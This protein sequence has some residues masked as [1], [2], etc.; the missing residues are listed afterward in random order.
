M[1]LLLSVGAFAELAYN[2]I[3]TQNDFNNNKTV[4]SKII[5][6]GSEVVWDNG[7]IRCGG[8]SS[9]ITEAP[10]WN[11]DDKG[12]V[13][14]LAAGVPNQLSFQYATN[15]VTSTKG[16]TDWSAPDWY[17][18]ESADGSKWTNAWT[19][20]S[21]STTFSSKTVNLSATTRFIR[22]YFS[23]NFAGYFKDIKVTEQVLM[24][25][26]SPAE[27]DFGTV[28]VDDVATREFTIN[29][30]GM[31]PT[32][33]S[34]NTH[35]TVTPESF[36]SLY[37]Y[38]KNQTIT[39]GL[40][41]TEAGEYNGT[42]TVAGRGKSA[43]VAVTAKVEKYDQ[44]INWDAVEAYN[45]G[46]AIPVATATSG[47]DVTYE[48][49]NPS[50]LKFENGAF[51]ILHSGEATVTAKQAGNYKYNAAEDVVKTITVTAPATY[52][53][54]EQT[55][56][57][58]SVTFFGKEYTESA[59]EDVKVG[60]NWMG[61]DSIVR[62]AI[63][64]NHA[65]FSEESLTITY[66]DRASWNGAALSDS[67][68]GVHT[69]VYV[70]TNA[71]GCDST[72][73]LTL[74]VNKQETLNVP[75][76]LAFCE[77]GSET[78]RGVEYTEAGTYEIPAEGEVRDTV[79]SV[80]V[81]ANPVYS[82]SETGKAKVGEG[83]TW[84][85]KNYETPATGTFNYEASYT[86]V[87]GC[88][89][90]YYLTLTVTKADVVEV[91]VEL[92]FCE[93]GSETFRGVEYTEANTYNVSVEGDIR[94]TL[95]VVNVI[96][97]QPS[98]STDTKTI[99]FGDNAK[100]NGI[101]LSDSTVGVHYVVYETTNAAGCDSTVTLTLTV[102]KME[103]FL[104][105]KELAFCEGD[106]VEYHGSWYFEEGED[107]ITIPGATRDTT[108][109]IYIT[110]YEKSYTTDTKTITFGDDAEWNGIALSDS[111][112]G[113]HTVI[114]ETT[115]AAGCDSTVTLTLTVNKMEDFL[116]EKELAFCEGDSVEYHG[117][118][119][120]EEGEDEI[121]IPGATRDTTITIYITV[122]E[123]SY[124][125][126]FLTDT[127]GN[128]IVLPEGEWILG[129]ETLS[130]TYELQE[131]D[132][133]GLEFVQYSETEHGCE[134]VTMLFVTVEERPINEGVE[135]VIADK[136]AQKFLQ[137]G[138][139]YIRRGEKE[140]SVDGRLVK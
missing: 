22:L 57:D 55:T 15:N 106:S 16:S 18:D 94:D 27:L 24:G 61:G 39:V 92:S 6:D 62:V 60:E 33:S 103:D 59:K 114:Y 87:N 13:I 100:W 5:P 109:T 34:A 133:E 97:K 74:T 129:E 120:F 8:A 14:A 139:I 80:K 11:W 125:E 1:S 19:I 118:W 70:T 112:V 75:V 119:Y 115:S 2:A 9:K 21:N 130:G 102:N 134:A 42:I 48:I 90:T 53:T 101:A 99:T 36:G 28:K 84:Q 31:V 41:T 126:I 111:T 71:A 116:A 29:Y 7:Q 56:C 69:M 137:N 73:T 47:L 64:I 17:V 127:V 82:F 98:F 46:D 32:A 68:V 131:A 96:V 3:L 85:G 12:I 123:K 93:G 26:P 79:Y 63:T 83:Y 37:D 117:S 122:H 88:D 136:S 23:G 72:V 25:V 10:A 35:F 128:T 105:E 138:A 124:E 104:A 135:N 113:V 58:E 52:G 65:T 50:V 91:P 89:S 81:T 108:I 51:V 140:Y 76:E 49:S 54:F 30:T 78:Y 45:F 66:G 110:V 107:E 77:G 121:T 40:I 4:I 20:N 132:I 43:N 38:K 86:T 44:A 67:T 95:Y